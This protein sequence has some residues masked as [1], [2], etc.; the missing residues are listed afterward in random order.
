[1]DQSKQ[2]SMSEY[3]YWFQ[4]NNHMGKFLNEKSLNIIKSIQD[5][6]KTKQR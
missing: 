3:R 6:Y 5:A 1:M 2:N 4:K